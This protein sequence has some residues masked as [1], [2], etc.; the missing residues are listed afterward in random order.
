MKVL[1]A[2]KP[3]KLRIVEM[4]KPAP[5]PREVV[6]KVLHCGICGTDVSI[7]DGTL[8]LGKGNEPIYPVRI[9][10]EWSGQVVELGSET[11]RLKVG[12]RII[13][14]TGYSCG[15]CEYCMHGE[16]GSCIEGRAIG[17]IGNCWPGAFAEYMLIPERLA[18]RLPDNV[19]SD[20]A[21]LVEPAGVGFYGLT[22][23]P[24]GPGTN[25]LV[26]GTGPIS[27]GGM[28]CAKGIG[29]GKTILAGRKDAKLAIGK[30][31]G[32]DILVNIDKENLYDVVMRETNGRGMDVV[33][34]STGAAELLNLSV[35]LTRAS[36][37]IVL[38]GFYER[39]IDDFAI[40]N[41]IVRN[42][43]LIGGAG[44]PDMQRRILDMLTNGHIDLRPMITDR[45][46]FERVLEAFKAVKE[47]NETRVKIL[48]DF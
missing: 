9:G 30:M 5:G 1:L 25:L 6:A 15:E 23:T 28:A 44:T 39:H 17:T 29:V 12:D 35:S 26:V 43:T 45:Y 48:V 42:C 37:W 38:P 3:G 7:A 14:D 8:N 33:M 46:P 27:L 47:K 36:G 32:A 20:V 34:D 40:D 18:F 19:P 21:A 13:S 31:L 22:K 11:K 41:I 16:F 24:V 10:H 4:E 2:E